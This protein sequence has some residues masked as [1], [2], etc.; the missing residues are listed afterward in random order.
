MHRSDPATAVRSHR[1]VARHLTCLRYDPVLALKLLCRQDYFQVNTRYRIITM[2][3][4]LVDRRGWLLRHFSE[5]HCDQAAAMVSLM[6][7]GYTIILPFIADAHWYTALLRQPRS[8]TITATVINTL[9][10]TATHH[11]QALKV[12]RGLLRTR[13]A[14]AHQASGPVQA[15]LNTCGPWTQAVIQ[16]MQHGRSP[17]AGLCDGL[18]R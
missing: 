3:P 16:A 18:L 1:K 7:H 10:G 12:A 6:A 15:D 13:I 5:D 11:Q 14:S 17:P 9:P 8:G 2:D 4:R